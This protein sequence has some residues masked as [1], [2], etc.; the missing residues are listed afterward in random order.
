MQMWVCLVLK[1][2]DET[3]PG[4]ILPVLLLN[5]YRCHMMASV[6]N[7]IHDLKVEILHI[8]GGC[9]GLCQPIDIGI[10]KPLKT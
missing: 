10:G 8:P 6:V 1:P 4:D 9:M 7:S 3:A 5:S 2:H